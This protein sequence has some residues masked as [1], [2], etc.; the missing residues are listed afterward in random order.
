MRHENFTHISCTSRQQYSPLIKF[1]LTI[2]LT[3]QN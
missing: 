1:L 2:D 3:C